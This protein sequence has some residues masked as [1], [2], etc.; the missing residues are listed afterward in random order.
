M[1]ALSS[2]RP[3]DS[4]RRS[5]MAQSPC[6]LVV[7]DRHAE[8]LGDE[9]HVDRTGGVAHRRRERHTPLLL[10]RAFGLDLPARETVELVTGE[11]QRVDDHPT[12]ALGAFG[13]GPSATVLPRDAP[14]SS[15]SMNVR[16]TR[17]ERAKRV[18]CSPASERREPGIPASQRASE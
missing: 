17:H 8:A 12:S 4:G 1:R 14:R 7:R 16:R 2:T 18:E 3:P 5:R 6:C 10:A 13:A 11:V 9:R 15:G